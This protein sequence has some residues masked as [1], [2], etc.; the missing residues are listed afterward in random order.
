MS[1][2]SLMSVMTTNP[3]WSFFLIT[4][5]GTPVPTFKK[6]SYAPT[7]L[8]GHTSE[9]EARGATMYW[10]IPIRLTNKIDWRNNER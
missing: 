6:I 9:T 3:K 4:L 2:L 8:L 10:S 5:S 7:G 1:L